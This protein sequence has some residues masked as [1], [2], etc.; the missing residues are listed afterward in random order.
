[1]QLAGSEICI[2]LLHERCAISD[3]IPNFDHIQI[4]QKNVLQQQTLCNT[5]VK[6]YFEQNPVKTLLSGSIRQCNTATDDNA[7]LLLLETERNKNAARSGFIAPGCSYFIWRETFVTFVGSLI[8]LTWP[9]PRNAHTHGA[10]ATGR[11]SD[12]CQKR[13]GADK[14][15][16]RPGSNQFQYLFN[17]LP[18]TLNT[19]L[20]QLL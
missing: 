16:A 9:I 13:W 7:T 8:V 10:T 2:G 11:E 1:M 6:T 15:L 17:L 19:V 3:L 12:I 14:S 5:A 4:S 18:T 20:S